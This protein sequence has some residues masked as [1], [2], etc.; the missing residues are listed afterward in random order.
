LSGIGKWYYEN[1]STR[2][3]N[4]NKI[5]EMRGLVCTNCHN[6]LAQALYAYDDLKNVVSQDGKTL[7]AAP[8]GEVIKT[9]AGGDPKR[10]ADVLADPRSFVMTGSPLVSYYAQHG[11]AVLVKASKDSGGKL[12]LAPWNSAA[13]DAVLYRAAS[14]GSDWWLAPAE[15]HCADCHL[16]PFVESEGGT[17]FPIDQPNKYS[18]FRYSKA[19]A[20][21]ACQSCHESAHGLYPT[22]FDG[23]K[24]TVDVTSHEQALQF[25]PDG[26]YA[27]PVTCAACHTVNERGVPVQLAGTGYDL[28]YWAAVVLVH[29]M[30]G[31]DDTLAVRDLVKKFPY[32]K[33]AETVARGW[34]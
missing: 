20:D 23:E 14:G 34:K 31:E 30:R 6:N 15:P 13:G 27:G 7:R 9:L 5:P 17:Y 29:S 11:S 18:L 32:K 8:I 24:D 33:A 4:G 19:H 2:D 21:L 10:F 28:D 16:A 26:K 22:R 1:V 25:S 12:T 3:E